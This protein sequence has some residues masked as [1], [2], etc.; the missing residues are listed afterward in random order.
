[1]R[2]LKQWLAHPLSRG[3]DL[4]DPR[5]TH[6]RLAIVRS[7]PFLCR[8]YEQWYRFIAASLPQTPGPVLELGSGAGFL[9]EFIPGLITSEVF[10]VP[11]VS[12]VLDAQQLP[13]A[14]Q[15]LRGIVMVDV[16]HHLPDVRR[17]LAEAS[18]CL[19]PGGRIIMVEPWVSWWSSL[20]YRKCHHEPFEAATADWA[21]PRSGPL[22]GAN[23]AL[24]WIVL[25]RDRAIFERDFPSLAIRTV[26]PHMPFCY[27]VS[28]G[29]SMRPLM[30][31][32]AFGVWRMLENTLGPWM[33][34]WGMFAEL[35]IERV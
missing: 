27:L 23:I 3:I 11:G 13:F 24:P 34:N 10:P 26:R 4:D 14:D 18:R 30:P 29:V 28:G 12:M 22:S 31:G 21:F 2:G 1:M 32:W 16:M 8:I 7:N 6:L 19:K 5:T 33:N 25:Q 9:R 20:I 35:V 15:S 17:F